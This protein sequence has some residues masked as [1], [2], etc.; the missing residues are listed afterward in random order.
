M[1]RRRLSEGVEESLFN[2]IKYPQGILFP[3]N[4]TESNELYKKEIRDRS[5]I[6]RRSLHRMKRRKLSQL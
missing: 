3:L 5:S 1:R 2:P 6:S 4:Y